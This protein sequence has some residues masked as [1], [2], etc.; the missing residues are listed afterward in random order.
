MRTTSGFT[1]LEVL[2][3]LLIITIGLL[4]LV[5]T[6]SNPPFESLRGGA[7]PEAIPRL[8]QCEGRQA[9]KQS[10]D[11]LGPLGLAMTAAGSHCEGS[12]RPVLQAPALRAGVG[13]EV[14]IARARRP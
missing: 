6:R 4:G 10:R 1:L 2:L 3:A 14:V 12:P 7:G 5:G 11:R 13:R 9:P 8:S